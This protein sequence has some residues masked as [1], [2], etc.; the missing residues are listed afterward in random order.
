MYEPPSPQLLRLLIE[1]RVCTAR[2]LRACRRHV[3]RLTR[4]LPAF[5]SVWLDA[6][7]QTRKLTPFQAKLLGST[8][9]Q[10]AVAGD[11][12][13]VNR[14]GSGPFGDT[15]LAR[16]PDHPKVRLAVKRCETARHQTGETTTRL[17]TLVRQLEP[18]TASGLCGP[19]ACELRDGAVLLIS[20]FQ[21][22]PA[23]K[24]LLLRRGRFPADVAWE[25][26][27]QCLESLAALHAAG[28][29]HS[30]PRLSNLRLGDDGRMVLVDCGVRGALEPDVTVHSGLPAEMYDGIAPELIGVGRSPTVQSD[31]YALGCGLW[32]LLAGRPPFPG[33]DPL[34]KIAAHQTRRIDDVRK[35]APDTPQALAEGI[36]WLTA[37]ASGDRPGSAGELLARWKPSRPAGRRR[38]RAFLKAFQSPPEEVQEK[39]L[40]WAAVAAALFAVSGLVVLLADAGLRS[41]ALTIV[42]DLRRAVPAQAA[43]SALKPAPSPLETTTGPRELP[44]PDPQGVIELPDA[45]PWL[46]GRVQ[47]TGPLV[48]RGAKGVRPVVVVRE[49]S[50]RLMALSVRLE[51]VSVRSE[52]S[53][54]TAGGLVLVTCGAFSVE[55]CVF[56]RS[57]E[58]E[59]SQPALGWKPI[60]GTVS[61]IVVKDCVF[62]GPG[63]A[64]YLDAAVP[65]S[66]ENCLHAGAGPLVTL[67][68][69]P[70]AGTTMPARFQNVTLR[71]TECLFRWRIR[72]TDGDTGGIRLEPSNCVFDLLPELPLVDLVRAEAD[73]RF[74]QRVRIVG[75][76]TLV[77]MDAE[78]AWVSPVDGVRTAL[79]PDASLEIEGLAREELV[80]AGALTARA[81]DSR[82]TGHDP[83]PGIDPSRLPSQ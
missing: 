18:L 68:N 13:L 48:V 51:N 56:E 81:A 82:I 61:P 4:D 76:D 42:G 70:P 78:A 6:L 8:Q 31:L 30:D 64:L 54:R 59:Q 40:S 15:Y 12:V 67:A 46:A 47:T 77:R 44:A 39:R 55:G 21:N 19:K 74:V 20:R 36:A 32:Q 71:Q 7:V 41:T 58:I 17:Q 34:A 72:A 24:E 28:V 3:R 83:A 23:L 14:L 65:L 1:S 22:G 50:L 37:H 57:P 53:D 79:P 73:A 5:D 43:V 80:F 2:D 10:K 29:I 62:R 26:G 63:A 49:S 52:S 9:P 11:L 66:V 33:A 25:I 45:G 27:R 75:T 60:P 16:H 69:D 38:L 35:W